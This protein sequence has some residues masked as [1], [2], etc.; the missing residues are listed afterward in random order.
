MMPE[1]GVVIYRE[2]GMLHVKCSVGILLACLLLVPAQAAT[3]A[4]RPTAFLG[5]VLDDT[6]L[7]GELQGS[8]PDE[9]SRLLLIDRELQQALVGSGCCAP[10]DLSPVA[11]RLHASDPRSCNGCDTDLA[12]TAG[13]RIVVSGWV[14]KVS[15]LILNMNAV[16]R[17]VAT[18]TVI[19]AGSVDLR[20]NTDES[21]SRA[22]AFL[23]RDRLHPEN[24]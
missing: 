5:F 14:Q 6:S 13:A 3:E 22:V 17:D 24:W 21:W 18:G 4:P 15:N 12:K 2:G 20:G 1:T 9:A 8:R 19:A 16:A 7:Q 23:V 10:V 11:A